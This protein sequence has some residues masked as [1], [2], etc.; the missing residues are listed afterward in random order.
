MPAGPGALLNR[1]VGAC[2]P[3]PPEK[4]KF[5]KPDIF[6]DLIP[7]TETLFLLGVLIFSNHEPMCVAVCLK[8]SLT[9][10]AHIFYRV[11]KQTFVQRIIDYHSWT[12]NFLKAVGFLSDVIV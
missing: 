5:K 11:N 7:Q 1:R 8:H 4:L 10:W 12:Q 9:F 2:S 3:K 6:E